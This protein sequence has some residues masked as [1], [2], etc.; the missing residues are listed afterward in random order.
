MKFWS[1]PDTNKKMC[2]TEFLKMGCVFIKSEKNKTINANFDDFIH[3]SWQ[4]THS[5]V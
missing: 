1:R 3:Q 4:G 2:I 5:L